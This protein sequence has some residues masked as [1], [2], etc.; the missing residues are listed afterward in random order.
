M[1]FPRFYPTTTPE[2]PAVYDRERGL[3]AIFRIDAN[4][5]E[6]ARVLNARPAMLE[7]FNWTNDQGEDQ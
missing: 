6:M 1:I 7:A 4:A 2:G 5:Q 3:R